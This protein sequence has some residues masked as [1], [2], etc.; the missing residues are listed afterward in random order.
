MKILLLS[1]N[2]NVGMDP[3]IHSADSPSSPVREKQSS[4]FLEHLWIPWLLHIVT[5]YPCQCLSNS[6]IMSSYFLVYLFRVGAG[7]PLHTMEGSEN[8]LWVSFLSFY[9]VGPGDQTRSQTWWQVPLHAEPI[10]QSPADTDCLALS[11]FQSMRLRIHKA[12]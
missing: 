9:H 1:K 11:P 4:F 10:R 3:W 5:Y 6:F 2:P 7:T 12:F 8:K